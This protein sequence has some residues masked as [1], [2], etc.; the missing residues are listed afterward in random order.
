MMGDEY[1]YVKDGLTKLYGYQ[2]TFMP[3]ADLKAMLYGTKILPIL[4]DPTSEDGD[5]DGVPDAIDNKKL[6]FGFNGKLKDKEFDGE[7]SVNFTIDYPQLFLNEKQYNKNLSTFASLL[8]HDVYDGRYVKVSDLSL[9]TEQDSPLNMV[10]LFGFNDIEDIVIY[11]PN[12]KFSEVSDTG[13]NFM[14]YDDDTT[15][16]VIGHRKVEINN[17]IREI[18]VIIVRGTNGTI[19]E[20]SSNFDVGADTDAYYNATGNHPEWINKDNHK[21]FDVAANRALEK[22]YDYISRYSLDSS[23]DRSF[24][25]TGHSRGGAI[26]NLIAKDLIDNSYNSND[27]VFG[28]T[29]AAPNNTTSLDYNNEKYKSIFNIVNEDDLVPC[30]P[31]DDWG[32]HK[33]GVYKGAS[34]ADS[35]EKAWENLTG[36]RDYNFN[37]RKDTALNEF[38]MI[39]GD[40]NELYEYT[41]DNNTIITFSATYYYDVQLDLNQTVDKYGDRISKYCQI[42]A[43]SIGFYPI[44]GTLEP[45]REI[46]DIGVKQT[47]AFMMMVL[48]DLTVS[49]ER[50]GQRGGD[51]DILFFIKWTPVGFKVAPKYETA[52]YSFCK[53]GADSASDIAM[54]FG[55]G[56][57]AHAHLPISYYLIANNI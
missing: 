6:Y 49:E 18:V 38:K 22:I 2:F 1:F 21:G 4:S 46:F 24:L 43:V 56:G 28:Y 37:G 20:W 12:A 48:A 7:I 35:Y 55:V 23:L 44:N 27:K 26:A 16:I 53:A 25:V 30:L 33:Y 45:E 41:D 36:I 42:Y 13:N 32:F 5:L 50:G 51:E 19:E 15:E 8:S 11:N 54:K 52:K 3:S 31:L 14:I 57:M 17:E 40:R 29:F 47:P 9:K 39:A 34:I 10:K